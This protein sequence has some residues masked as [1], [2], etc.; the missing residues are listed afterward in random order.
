L[1]FGATLRDRALKSV[2]FRRSDS[3]H[4]D[5]LALMIGKTVQLRFMTFGWVVSATQA[6]IVETGA[7]SQ[8]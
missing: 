8:P 5:N 2:Q 1:A 7:F 3:T 4:A 6:L